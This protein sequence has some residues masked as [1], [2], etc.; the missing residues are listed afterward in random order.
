MV[1][2]DTRVCK[3]LDEWTDKELEMTLHHLEWEIRYLQNFGYAVHHP[4][5][6]E[7]IQAS[8]HQQRDQLKKLRN[9]REYRIIQG[10]Y[11]PFLEERR[12]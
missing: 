3:P 2:L 6:S 12:R 8:V 10:T 4:T 1:S 11:Q 5:I 7:A 9:E